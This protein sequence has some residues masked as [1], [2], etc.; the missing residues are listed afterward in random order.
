MSLS[1]VHMHSIIYVCALIHVATGDAATTLLCVCICMCWACVN[2]LLNSFYQY[3]YGL[4]NNA[5]TLACRAEQETQFQR[6]SRSMS[7]RA[8]QHSASDIPPVHTRNS[9]PSLTNIL[10]HLQLKANRIAFGDKVAAP[11]RHYRFLCVVLIFYMWLIKTLEPFRHQIR[12]WLAWKLFFEDIGFTGMV[13]MIHPQ[14]NAA[15]DGSRNQVYRVRACVH[16]HT[17]RIHINTTCFVWYF[18]TVMCDDEC[19]V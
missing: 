2:T 19:M 6:D 14:R 18:V 1:C 12:V 3:T 8:R 11:H 17:W 5:T 7:A 4:H 13:V 10:T 16:K 15:T 9:H